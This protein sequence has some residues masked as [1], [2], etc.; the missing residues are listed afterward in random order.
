MLRELIAAITNID[1]DV[2]AIERV[3]RAG[4]I[5]RI[6]PE[7]IRVILRTKSN[8]HKFFLNFLLA[9]EKVLKSLGILILITA[10][11][12]G[13]M[14]QSALA[15]D[16]P[17]TERLVTRNNGFQQS[18]STD[19]SNEITIEHKEA[20]YVP[21]QIIVMF[22]DSAAVRHQLSIISKKPDIERQ[23]ASDEAKKIM[24][25]AFPN[26]KI[27]KA[28]KVFKDIP[29]NKKAVQSKLNQLSTTVRIKTD[30]D[31]IEEK[32]LNRLL[33]AEEKKK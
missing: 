15:L 6:S 3:A 18:N 32:R 21:N 28:E 2:N 33:T 13:I 20:E 30:I 29:Q 10:V 16:I 31:R 11:Y 25:S 22:K 9:L 23:I 5:T 19:S 7:A 12:G 1:S 14:I 17:L 8:G 26:L 24:S 4:Q 27:K